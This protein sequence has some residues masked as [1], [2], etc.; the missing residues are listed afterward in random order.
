[1]M[2]SP[3][4][5]LARQLGEIETRRQSR[6][7]SQ[8]QS[9]SDSTTDGKNTSYTDG[10]STSRRPLL[11]FRTS[12]QSSSGSSEGWSFSR[13]R[14]RSDSATAGWSDSVHKRLLLNPDEI[15]R[16]LARV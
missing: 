9:L 12:K 13:S 2:I 1:M 11:H 10:Y 7:G 5:Y 15:G 3:R 8:S 4:S 6:S 16:M 14:S